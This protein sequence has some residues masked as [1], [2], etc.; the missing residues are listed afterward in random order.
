MNNMKY[1]HILSAFTLCS[2]ASPIHEKHAVFDTSVVI[3]EHTMGKPSGED[4]SMHNL[5]KRIDVQQCKRAVKTLWQFAGTALVFKVLA[6]LSGDG[7]A[8]MPLT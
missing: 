3:K 6:K 7:N 4:E 2:Y 5:E 1:I 8:N